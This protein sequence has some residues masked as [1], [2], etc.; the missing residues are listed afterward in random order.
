MAKYVKIR[1]SIAVINSLASATPLL[2]DDDTD[3][4]V[5]VTP[6]GFGSNGQLTIN[7]MKVGANEDG[8]VTASEAS[9]HAS[10]RFSLI[11]PDGDADGDAQV[12][13]AEFMTNAQATYEA[14]DNNGDG[15]V[16]VWE[17][18]AQ[19]KPF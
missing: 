1:G 17:F 9:L 3:D 4:M 14:A 8:R 2:A 16:T 13:L 6:F 11:D 19:Q 10:A 5:Q 18:R 12:T 7:A 15:K